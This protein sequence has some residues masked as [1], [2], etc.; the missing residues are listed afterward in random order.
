MKFAKFLKIPFFT[1]HLRWLLLKLVR[2]HW[3]LSMILKASNKSVWSDVF[4]Y[5]KACIFWKCI[6]YTIRRDKTQMLKKIPLDKINS[7]KR[8]LFFI[9][10]ASTNHSFTFNVWFLYE[11]K[12]K[13]RPSKTVCGIFHVRFPFVFVKVYIFLQENWWTFRL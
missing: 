8:A 5:V 2:I 6:Q 1:G 13:V 11:L 12:L 3:R 7:T 4:R 10:R 9:S